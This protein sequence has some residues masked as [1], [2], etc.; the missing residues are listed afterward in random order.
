MRKS[1]HIC[2][3]VLLH[4]RVNRIVNVTWHVSTRKEHIKLTQSED[5]NADILV[6]VALDALQIAM[7]TI[8]FIVR[9]L[10]SGIIRV[11]TVFK[12][13][14][15]ILGDLKIHVFVLLLDFVWGFCLYIGDIS[16]HCWYIRV[17]STH[18]IIR[19]HH[20]MNRFF[21]IFTTVG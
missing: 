19:I 7:I 6:I 8:K 2:W 5:G 12:K 20:L 16:T 11:I 10:F 15:I 17:I 21:Q 3:E 13:T 14:L 4:I 18:I 1:N 9:E